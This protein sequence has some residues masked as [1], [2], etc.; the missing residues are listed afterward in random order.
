MFLY[1]STKSIMQCEASDVFS[2]ICLNSACDYSVVLWSVSDVYYF[3]FRCINIPT[4]MTF[5]NTNVCGKEAYIFHCFFFLLV[6]KS[7][8]SFSIR[9]SCFSRLHVLKKVYVCKLN[10]INR[11]D[12]K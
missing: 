11:M 1:I 8:S 10:T 9:T 4:F 5:H 12:N 6:L 3:E 7:I 2:H